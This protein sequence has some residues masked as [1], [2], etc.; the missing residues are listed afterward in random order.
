MAY[1]EKEEHGKTS[2]SAN[3]LSSSFTGSNQQDKFDKTRAE[4]FAG[5][6]LDIL[7]GGT[8]SLMVSIGHQT[9]LF[10]VM[11]KLSASTSEEIA[12][13]ANLNERY[14]R[15]WLGAL[16]TASIVEYDPTKQKYYLPAEHAAFLT[17][18]AGLNNVAVFTQYIALMGE[19]EQKII[20]CFHKGGGVP[21]SAY[22]RFQE[23]QAEET[24][25]IFDARLLDNIIPL[26]D[27]LEDRLNSGID[28]LDVGCG[29]GRAI[30]IMA[31]AYPKSRFVGY[32]IST[33]G[34]ESANQEA[35]EW[36]LTNAKFEVKD[37][38]TINEQ[39][40]YDLITAFDTIHDQ[41]QPTKVLK[42]IYNALRKGGV[43][44]MQDIAAS[45]HLHENMNNPLAPTL[46]TFSTMHCMT[47]SLA[48]NGEG[49]GT[50]WGKQKAEEKLREAGFSYPIEVKQIEGDILNYYYIS[51]K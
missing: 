13:A 38:T 49:L 11:S 19:V 17:H 40:K 15:E 8:I 43:F 16:V 32:D 30:N 22:P 28:V 6:M 50:V 25:R 47:V 12:T 1:E 33:E 44:L 39:E 20:E 42:K 26:V 18:E 45:S 27:G 9:H 35:K 21:Y 48:Y 7:N 4:V 41:A 23:L 3:S 46:Y 29:R 51:R 36:S 24:A 37:V 2:N 14:V 10:D 34:I 5:K 31:R